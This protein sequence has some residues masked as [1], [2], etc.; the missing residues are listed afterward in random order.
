VRNSRYVSRGAAV[1]AVFLVAVGCTVAAPRLIP[2]G[3]GQGEISLPVQP[4][5][6]VLADP[7]DT[8]VITRDQPLQLRFTEPLAS[9]NVESPRGGVRAWVASDDPRTVDL[10]VSDPQPGEEFPVQLTDVVGA[11]G[12]PGSESSVTL[13]VPTAV[14]LASIAGAAPTDKMIVVPSNTIHL[15]WNKPI[16]SLHYNVDGSEESWSGSPTASM[17][18]QVQLD[19]G[20][21][22]TLNLEDA[23]GESGGWLPETQSI[24]LVV[25][26]P[27]RVTGVWPS[28]DATGIDPSG[29]PIITFS[30]PIENS[31]AAEAAIAFDPATPGSFTWLA[32]NRV[33]FMPTDAFPADSAITISVQ[34]GLKGESGSMLDQPFATTFQTGPLKV[35]HVSLSKQQMVLTEDGN[36]VW[37]A[38][39]ATGVP[40]APTPP[41]TYRVEDKLAQARFRGVNPDGSHYD[42]P[43]VHWVMP[44][45]GDY[46]IHGAYW[47][48]VFGRPG[49]DGCVSLSD[50]N[51]KVVFDW[52]DEGT[53]LIITP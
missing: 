31:A 32:P 36:P 9:I 50:A 21:T 13:Q 27:L 20:K 33:R 52:A 30:E 42:I 18:L 12:A 48:P 44:F 3:G 4:R 47:R 8:Q 34:A 1:A 15:E 2:L 23:T 7:T 19:Q 38:P 46:T 49:S 16:T 40:A 53:P 39:V 45:M 10:S 25:P 51:A 24:Q 5:P 14:D 28:A 6:P 26:P 22:V 35:I 17:D 37:S 11:N 29:Y 41:G 43:D